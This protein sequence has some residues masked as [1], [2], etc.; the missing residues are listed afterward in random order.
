MSYNPN[1]PQ[2][3][4]AQVVAEQKK[5]SWLD[6]LGQTLIQGDANWQ[7][8]DA[9]RRQMVKK[10]LLE[11]G[12]SML[13]NPSGYGNSP[14]NGIA[15]GLLKGIGQINEESADLRGKTI[16]IN[17]QRLTDYQR[18]VMAV[19][20]PNT[21]PQVREAALVYLK[22]NPPAKAETVNTL[23]TPKGQIVQGSNKGGFDLYE[24]GSTSPTRYGGNQP[25]KAEMNLPSIDEI[26]AAGQV[27]LRTQPPQV[28][29][30]WKAQQVAALKAATGMGNYPQ[31]TQPPP[32]YVTES[33]P[34]PNLGKPDAPKTVTWGEPKPFMK[35]GKLVMIQ[36]GSDGSE[37]D[38]PDLAP[39]PPAKTEA[40]M[41]SE[42]NRARG[43]AEM[44]RV[45]KTMLD[46]YKTLDEARGITNT[47]RGMLD[48]VQA[49]SRA[50]DTG[51]FI[52]RMV[53]SKDQS[54]RDTINAMKPQVLSAIIAASGMSAK[55][56]DSNAEMKLWLSA[57]S[58][59][60]TSYQ[61]VLKVTDNLLKKFTGKGI[62]QFDEKP[63]TSTNDDAL[64]NKY[65][66]K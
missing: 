26:E 33:K 66:S 22:L 38:R 53:G 7:P 35:N 32:R 62:E 60:Q 17:G 3:T 8:D 43:A 64:I 36:N 31:A 51:Q 4:P 58:D 61:T 14:I 15:G 11:A 6:R 10:G 42:A 57:T 25:I 59:P 20:D 56:L 54:A 45:L 39:P 16:G 30:A 13:A 44:S 28:V 65:L 63:K 48:N 1:M 21:P 24:T 23:I 18:A 46:E 52:G 9:T 19:Q 50:S 55:Q 34:L 12:L 37:R 2:M 40:Q 29:N 47:G 49:Y 41:A 27:M 5:R